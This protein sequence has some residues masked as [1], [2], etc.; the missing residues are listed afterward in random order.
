MDVVLHTSS[1]PWY[2]VWSS[3]VSTDHAGCMQGLPT[4]RSGTRKKTD[5]QSRAGNHSIKKLCDNKYIVYIISLIVIII[6]NT[7]YTPMLCY[8]TSCWVMC[9]IHGTVLNILVVRHHQSRDD[10]VHSVQIFYWL[11]RI[12]TIAAERKMENRTTLA[13]NSPPTN[14]DQ[15]R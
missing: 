4:V 6:I 13:F 3:A 11:V 1:S 7:L 12:L 8:C 5:S 15:C 10:L 2:A 14:P 9:V